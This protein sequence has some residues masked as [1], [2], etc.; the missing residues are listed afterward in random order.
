MLLLSQ[1]GF[2]GRRAGRLRAWLRGAE[3]TPRQRSPQPL[4][5]WHP[6][7]GSRGTRG[8]RWG[9]APRGITTGL[10]GAVGSGLSSGQEGE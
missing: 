8:P 4:G 7:H 6:P 10:E 9:G 5:C 2:P 1:E 3:V